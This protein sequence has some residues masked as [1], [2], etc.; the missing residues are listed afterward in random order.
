VAEDQTRAGGG[1]AGVPDELEVGL[2]GGAAAGGRGGSGAGGGVTIKGR[3]G[4]PAAGGNDR[5]NV[6]DDSDVG[7]GDLDGGGGVVLAPR[8]RARGSGQRVS[9]LTVRLSAA[10]RGEVVAASGAA[11]V[12]AA[13][14]TASAVLAAARG[15]QAPG[16]SPV[17][18]V[19]GELMAAR[20]QLRGYAVN[21][22]QAAKVLNA[23]GGA[24]EWLEAAVE[25]SDAAVARVDEATAAVMRSLR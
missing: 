6:G 11:G 3:D 1:V 20:R 13:G 25:A 23:G 10:E 16:G 22:N 18:A 5:S 17:R 15:G 7:D 19:L 4:G 24:P 14:F 9:R 8:R 21:V 2:S 12:T